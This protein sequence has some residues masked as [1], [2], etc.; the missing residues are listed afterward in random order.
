MPFRD[1]SEAGASIMPPFTNPDSATA[2]ENI[3]NGFNN[4][5]SASDCS[6]GLVRHSKG[7]EKG[8]RKA[9]VP[10]ASCCA[11]V[12]PAQPARTESFAA[13]VMEVGGAYCDG[14]RR[15]CKRTK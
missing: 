4:G 9:G 13:A 12:L 7:K 5:A 6:A 1:T 3:S 14:G 15:V 2:V 10:A 8:H 11:G